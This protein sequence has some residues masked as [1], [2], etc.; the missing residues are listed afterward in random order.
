MF[1]PS[2]QKI[3]P[4]NRNWSGKKR[5][6]SESKQ[7]IQLPRSGE[8]DDTTENQRF[9][10][11]ELKKGFTHRKFANSAKFY[12]RLQEKHLEL[13]PV[14]L[15][16]RLGNKQKDKTRKYFPWTSVYWSFQLLLRPSTGGLSQLP[17]HR[18][19]TSPYNVFPPTDQ[20]A[21]PWR[22]LGNGWQQSMSQIS[23]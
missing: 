18:R 12:I 22:S 9:H 1:L 2:P 5:Q 11:L 8:Y 23:L 13:I 6:S 17:I 16:R 7:E 14:V 20:S 19:H 15:D 10:A 3:F 21:S 4:R